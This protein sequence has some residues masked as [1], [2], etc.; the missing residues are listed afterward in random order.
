VYCVPVR[1]EVKL[2]AAVVVPLQTVWLEIPVIT[3]VGNTT[4]LKV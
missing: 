3:G 4:I 1:L 2:M